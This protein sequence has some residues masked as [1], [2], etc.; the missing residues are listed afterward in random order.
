MG[1]GRRGGTKGG[2]DRSYAFISQFSNAF[3]AVT[4]WLLV[5][6]P[7]PPSDRESLRQHHA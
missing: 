4:F 1:P 7:N 2:G 3:M 6:T 5:W